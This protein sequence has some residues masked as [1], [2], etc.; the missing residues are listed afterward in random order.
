MKAN[1][2]RVANLLCVHWKDDP[3]IV[4]GDIIHEVENFEHEYEPIPLTEEWL[5]KFGLLNEN[6]VKI[7]NSGCFLTLNNHPK[8]IKPYLSGAFGM[9]I[10]DSIQYVHQLQNLYFALTGEELTIK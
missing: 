6:K 1:E 10:L 3:V 2:L 5:V 4:T 9:V 8:G 7:G